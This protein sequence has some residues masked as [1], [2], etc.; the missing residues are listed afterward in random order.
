MAGGGGTRFWPRSRQHRPKQFLHLTGDGTLLQQALERIEVAGGLAQ[1]LGHHRGSLSHR[2]RP[3]GA[4][5]DCRADRRRTGRPRHGGVHRRRRRP[6][7]PPGSAGD[8]AGHAGRSRHRAG[9]GISPGRA[10]RPASGRRASARADH[11]RHSPHVPGHGLWLHPQ[12]PAARPAAR[13]RR[14][15]RRR[16]PRK[17]G[18][19]PG[20]ADA[21]HRRIF[22]EQ[23]HLPVAGRDHSRRPQDQSSATARR[24]RAHRLRPGALHNGR[25]SSSREYQ[26]RW[27]ASAS[28]MRSWKKRR[29]C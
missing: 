24:R 29:T 7:R 16:L 28:I 14:L 18:H 4:A 13:R 9:P 25:R 21:Q 1:H 11:F 26:D 20:R 3:A 23:R 19:R 5:A 6:D 22:L 17:A 12:R 8:H 2:G 10:G 27:N 15:S